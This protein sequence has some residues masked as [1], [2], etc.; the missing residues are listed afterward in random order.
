MVIVTPMHLW[1]MFKIN[2]LGDPVVGATLPMK[3]WAIRVPPFSNDCTFKSIVKGNGAETVF[4]TTA[5]PAILVLQIVENAS[6]LR[7]QLAV[8]P[9]LTMDIRLPANVPMVLTT[10]L[11]HL[12]SL[13][14]VI[15]HHVPGLYMDTVLLVSTMLPPS[16]W[17]P[18]LSLV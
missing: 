14:V 17:H 10:L 18:A 7:F 4:A 13:P 1:D 9:V 16:P 15:L 12:P 11:Q 6:V 3:P 8:H 5:K 2:V